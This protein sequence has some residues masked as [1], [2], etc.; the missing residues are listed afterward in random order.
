MRHG[1]TVT[2]IRVTAVLDGGG[3]RI[4]WEDNGVGVPIEHK[5][6]IFE[7]GFGSHTG[8]GL[9]L[10]KE[11]LSITGATI[12]ETGEPGKGARFEITVP[13]GNARYG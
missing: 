7:R 13:E 4:V 3:A 12:R 9:F 2:E 6:R 1:R 11:V 5:Q 10:V 8:L